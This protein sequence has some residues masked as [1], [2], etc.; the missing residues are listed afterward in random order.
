MIRKKLGE[1]T[2][3][4][5][6]V[7]VPAP[8]APPSPGH[9]LL[10][11]GRRAMLEATGRAGAWAGRDLAPR[12]R[13][14]GGEPGESQPGGAASGIGM[15]APHPPRMEGQVRPARV[16]CSSLLALDAFTHLCY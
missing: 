10:A 15:R 1:I 6:E 9:L 5:K 3:T 8:P 14:V 2:G 12:R 7:M 11:S 4:V 13:G 16:P